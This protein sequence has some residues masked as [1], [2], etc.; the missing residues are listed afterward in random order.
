[1]G[2]FTAQFAHYL[3]IVAERMPALKDHDILV[4]NTANPRFAWQ[5]HAF[6]LARSVYQASQDNGFFGVNM[7]STGGGKTIGNARIMYGLSDLGKGE[8]SKGARF[9]IA[10]GLRVLTLQTGLSFRQDLELSDSQLAILVGGQAHKK[11]FEL[12]NLE[13]DKATAISDEVITV[14]QQPVF[15]SESSETLVDEYLD[16]DIDYQAYADL[17]IDTILD[18]PKARDLLFSPIVT[19]TIDHMIQASECKRGGKYI[20]PMLRLLSGDLI[21]DEPDDFD[22]NDLPAL[23]RLVHLAGVFGSRVLLSSATLTPDLITGLFEAYLAGRAIFNQSQNKP[24][25]QVVCA[26]FDEQPKAMMS[27]PCGTIEQFILTH[28]TFIQK[29]LQFLQAQPI[30]RKADILPVSVSYNHEKPERFYTPIGNA[31]LQGAKTLHKRYHSIDNI[32]Q[33]KVSIGLVRVANIKNITQLAMSLLQHCQIPED[34]QIHLACYHAKQV[35]ILRNSLEHKLDRIL[36]RKS[37][38]AQEIFTHPEIAN[39][40]KHPQNQAIRNHI[41][42]V[43]ATPVAEVGRDH[44]YDWAI[45]EPSSMRSIIQL[46]GRVWRHRPDLQADTPNVLILQYNF[47]Y[48]K[49]QKPVF[50]YPGFETKKFKPISYDIATLI[51]PHQLEQIDAQPRIGIKNSSMPTKALIPS[52]PVIA[53]LSQLEHSVM[54]H[55]M[56]NPKTNY[57]NAYWRPIAS[58][59]RVHTHLQQI[60][61]FRDDSTMPLED[62][63]IIPTRIQTSDAEDLDI[64]ALALSQNEGQNIM[65]KDTPFNAYLAEDI[66][67][68]GLKEAHAQQKRVMPMTLPPCQKGISPWLASDLATELQAIQEKIPDKSIISLAI[69]FCGVSLDKESSR[70]SK[71]WQFNEFLGFM[72]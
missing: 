36:K 23:G 66:Y 4:R 27:E 45:V 34:T 22:Q 5:N 53:T 69:S 12:N 46:A 67:S 6:K 25:P 9:T 26:W 7:S 44:D 8:K 41:F 11:L 33:K 30:R 19:C 18:N 65:S 40:L 54:A 42:I 20:A 21:L 14:E 62:W 52:N 72:Q 70:N 2:T 28:D 43:L 39:E 51:L 16:S 56:H 58:S 13:P 35:L 50:V 60:T 61:P 71:N 57:V 29:R 55:L 48:L 38:Y 64:Q 47:R 37:D 63:L 1:M 59:N 15:G 32:T 17:N 3:P 68:N 24:K 10:L 31:I 49:N